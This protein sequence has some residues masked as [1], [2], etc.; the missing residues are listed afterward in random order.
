MSRTDAM[1]AS[2][3]LHVELMEIK[4]HKCV[5]SNSGHRF[6]F[7]F[8]D[9][10]TYISTPDLRKCVITDQKITSQNQTKS[11]SQ[12]EPIQRQSTTIL[13]HQKQGHNSCLEN[14]KQIETSNKVFLR[15]NF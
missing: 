3:V 2:V 6:I 4:F 1:Y 10:A 14:T 13:C 8:S 12:S 5:P 15:I 7:P 9:T 11:L